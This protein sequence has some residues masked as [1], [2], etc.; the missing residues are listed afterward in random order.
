M[1]MLI[2]PK[3]LFPGARVAAVTLS[4]GGP[5]AFPHRYQAGKQQFQDAFDVEV[6]EMPHTLADDGWLARNPKARAEDL[7]AAF[8]DDRIDGIISTI[9]GDDSMRLI[10]HVDLTV[11]RNNPKVFCGYSDTTVSHLLCHKAGLVSFYGPAFMSGFAENG[12]IPP[13]LENSFRQQVFAENNLIELTPNTEGWTVEHLGW[14]DPARQS[15][16]RQLTPCTGWQYLQGKGIHR[17]HLL[18]GCLEVLEM[19]RGTPA[20]PTPEQWQGAVLFLE[21]SEEGAPPTALIRSL[22]SFAAEG[23]LKG[24]AG[25]LF[26]RPGGQLNP[27]DFRKYDEALIQVIRDEEGLTELP[28]VTHMDFGHTDPMMTFAIGAAIRINCDSQTLH[29]AF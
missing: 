27:A 29:Q 9:G 2:K 11:I 4:W 3:P 1:L 20:W 25:V 12:G 24:L 26:G 15:Q 22:R 23:V 21:T 18:G 10:P 16:R 28:I 7:M 14:D 8:A 13:Y 17:G 6:V 5:A 19:L